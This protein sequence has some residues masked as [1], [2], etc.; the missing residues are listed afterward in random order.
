MHAEAPEP[1]AMPA[2]AWRARLGT[3]TLA[4]FLGTLNV[5][6]VLAMA[7]VIQRELGLSVAQFGLLVTAYNGAQAVGALPAGALVDRVGVGW[8]LVAAHALLVAAA[9]ALSQ[10]ESFAPALAA[11]AAMGLG[12]SIMNPATARGVLEW[13]PS[14]RRA[15]A[16]GIKQTG[17]PLGGMLAAGNGAL[18]TVLSWQSILWI[19][20]GVTALGALLCLWLAER[21]KRRGGAA[22][23]QALADLA[24]VLRNLNLGN[25][26]AANALYNMGQANFFA[27]LTLFLRAAAHASQPVA[28]L[29][30]GLAQAAS[31]AGRLVW[32]IVSDTLFRGRRKALVVGLGAGGGLFLAAMAAVGPGWGV[33]PIAALA[34]FLGLTIASYAALAQTMA[35]ETMEPRLA[36]SAVGYNMVATSLGGTIGPALFGAIIGLT[37]D[38][39]DGWLLSAGLVVAGTAMIG[40]WFRE[41]R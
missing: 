41:R 11:L 22:A 5:V 25:F 18:V 3:I 19:N 21:P 38:F 30:L 32:G 7:P 14:R 24:R 16:M 12:Y 17:V 4:H 9:V 40:L 29:C 6:S 20:A 27:F 35:V 23:G 33:V 2:H 13:F 1:P 36:G 26:S 15:T 39:A 10:A 37:G 28:G 8:A 34:V 31:A